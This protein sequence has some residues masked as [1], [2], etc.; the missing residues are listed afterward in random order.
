MT[1]DNHIPVSRSEA[2]FSWYVTCG[3]PAYAALAGVPYHLTFFNRDAIIE[4]YEVGHPLALS[5]FGPE[6]R[7]SLPG[8]SGI[9]YGH[10]NC[11][12]SS[13]IFPVNSDVAHTPIYRSLKE[14]IHALQLKMDWADAGLMPA[15]LHLWQQLKQHFPG[16]DIRFQGFGVEGPVTTAWELRGHSFFTDLYD[17]PQD[18]KEF[19]SLVTESIVDY[20]I[21]QRQVNG[22]PEKPASGIG[23]VDD[24]SALLHPRHW[25]EYVL[26]FQQ[27]Y[28]CSQTEG[29]RHAHIE[30]LAPAHIPFLDDLKLDSFDPSVSPGLS[31]Q[32]FTDRCSVPFRWRLNAMHVRDLSVEQVCDFVFDAVTAGASGVFSHVGR[33][34]TTQDAALRLSAFMGA[35]K[36]VSKLLESGV[37]QAEVKHHKLPISQYI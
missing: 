25:R 24:I 16:M 11:L 34:M 8:W 36:H 5:L 14:G 3:M 4:A 2:P 30:G 31:P 15:Y 18:T 1:G 12:G 35:V 32:D 19:L 6:V 26:P 10:V 28:F 29:P 23:M 37:P 13:L 7:Y 22:E 21:F 20:C 27:S 33:I 17:H 9:S